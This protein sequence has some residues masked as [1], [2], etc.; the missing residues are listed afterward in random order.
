MPFVQYSNFADVRELNAADLSKA[1]VEGFRS[2]K[3][4]RHEAIEVSDEVAEALL[5]H[6]LFATEF[7]VADD[8]TETPQDTL[9]VDTGDAG[10]SDQVVDATTTSGAGNVTTS[11]SGSQASGRSRSRGTSTTR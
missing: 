9:D 8:P 10:G 5:N 2:T 3:F 6:E 4:P 7:T 1:G 11:T